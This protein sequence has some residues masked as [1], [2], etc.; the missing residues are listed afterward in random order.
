MFL[1]ANPSTHEVHVCGLSK[2]AHNGK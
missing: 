1:A 2:P